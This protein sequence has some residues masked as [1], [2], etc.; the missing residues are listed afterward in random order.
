M[1]MTTRAKFYKLVI[2]LLLVILYQTQLRHTQKV[3]PTP[4]ESD[5]NDFLKELS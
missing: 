3:G 2:R 1:N 5:A 4:L